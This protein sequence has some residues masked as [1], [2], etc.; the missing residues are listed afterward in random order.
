MSQ[1]EYARMMDMVNPAE[2]DREWD[3]YELAMGRQ[4]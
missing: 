4:S 2:R 3:E 1:E